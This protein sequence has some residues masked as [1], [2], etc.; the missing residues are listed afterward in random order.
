MKA[1]KEVQYGIETLYLA[2]C[3]KGT[4]LRTYSG[5]IYFNELKLTTNGEAAAIKEKRR[6]RK[7]VIDESHRPP[8]KTKD[9]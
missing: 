5:E 6:V 7:L 8:R 9:Y 4:R 3:L 2:K 1:F